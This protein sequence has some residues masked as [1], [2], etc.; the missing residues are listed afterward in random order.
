MHSIWLCCL[1][2]PQS[3]DIVSSGFEISPRGLLR[4]QPKIEPK[5]HHIEKFNRNMVAVL[6][7]LLATC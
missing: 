1:N 3:G 7:A 6:T 5:N 2:Q 4:K